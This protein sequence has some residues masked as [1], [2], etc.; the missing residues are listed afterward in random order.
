MELNDELLC[1]YLDGELDAAMREQVMHA[2]ESDAGGRVRLERM[3]A[4]DVRL[5]REILPD[6]APADDPIAE[7][8]RRHEAGETVATPTR[9]RWIVP[10]AIAAAAASIVFAFLF[11]TRG[12]SPVDSYA[13]GALRAALETR[14]SGTVAPTDD[15]AVSILL[16]LRTRSGALCRLY[17][18]R[19][20]TTAEGLAC[21]DDAG[22]KIVA[23]DATVARSE[24]FHTAGASAVLDA[25]MERLG[26]EPLDAAAERE[27]LARG[28]QSG[29]R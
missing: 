3:R 5:R 12:S 24:G 4:A 11:M 21:R 14:P 22:W 10:G 8:I 19:A 16:T 6:A 20:G 29:P 28:W 13:Q 18:S 1:A 17:E 23:W 27:A 25:A 26:G 9:R 7:Y 15:A 2:L